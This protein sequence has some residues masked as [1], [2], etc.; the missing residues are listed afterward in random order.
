MDERTLLQVTVDGETRSYPA[1]TPYRQIAADVQ[2]RYENEILL[3]NRA[4]QAAG[5]G[6]HAEDGHRRG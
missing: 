6:L 3:V 2:D 1:G 4:P 5:P